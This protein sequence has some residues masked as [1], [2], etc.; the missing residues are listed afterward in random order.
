MPK[1]RYVVRSVVHSVLVLSAFDSDGEALTLSTIAA[2][3][4]LGSSTA[5]RLLYTLEH[6]GFVEKVAKNLYRRRSISVGTRIP[7][8]ELKELAG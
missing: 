2:R 6:C 4:R 5:F 3:S 8:H 7:T 1:H